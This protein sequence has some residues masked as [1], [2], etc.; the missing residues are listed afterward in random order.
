MKGKR[1]I[2]SKGTI[3]TLIAAAR[4]SDTFLPDFVPIPVNRGINQGEKADKNAE[5]SRVSRRMG[6]KF[7]QKSAG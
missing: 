7:M 6:I 1:N 4:L 3:Y 2:D 5:I